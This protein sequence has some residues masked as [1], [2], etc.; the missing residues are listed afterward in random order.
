[1][2]D[3]T[4]QPLSLTNQRAMAKVDALLAQEGLQ[5]DA[6][7]EVICG[8]Y[9]EDYE[10]IATGACF[11]NSLR[12]IAVDHRYQSLGLLN[13]LLSSLIT[14]QLERGHRHLFLYTKPANQEFFTQN[15]FY[16][17]AQVSETLVFMENQRHGFQNYLTQLTDETAAWRAGTP[18]TGASTSL[19]DANPIQGA[20]VMNANPFTLGHL[21]LIQTALKAVDLLHVFIVRSDA[22]LVPFAVRKQLFEAG[23]QGLDRII[24]HDTSDYLI[25]TATFPSY[26]L[27]EDDSVTVIQAQLDA[28]LFLTIAATLGITKRFLGEEPTS[29]VTRQYNEVLQELLPAAG[30]DLTILPRLAVDGTIVSAST[31]RQAIHDGQLEQIQAWVPASTYAYFSSDAAAPVIE[32]IQASAHV[33]HH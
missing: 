19:S 18:L 16:P 29:T 21:H 4:V 1:M 24:L 7:L 3:Y 25:S 23:I 17:I 30:V 6:H 2:M 8:I 32:V 9:N 13:K 14:L 27:K 31:V 26:F 15:G 22:S 10:L 33:R 5:R 12:C 11:A 28:N 20:I